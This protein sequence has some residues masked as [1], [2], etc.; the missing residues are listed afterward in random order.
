MDRIVSAQAVQLSEVE[1]HLQLSAE[2]S[3]AQ[4][5][6]MAWQVSLRDSSISL[7][8]QLDGADAIAGRVT[9][10]LDRVNQA[11]AQVE[12]ASSVLSTVLSMVTIPSQMVEHLHLRLLGVFSMPATVLYF[13]KPRKYSY[14]LMAFYGM[15]IQRF[16][17]VWKC[18]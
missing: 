5:S 6:N 17:V 1:Q 18:C 3:E 10:R 11:L 9:S 4:R 15:L 16:C 2:L 13:W 8:T 12:R 7:A 14:S